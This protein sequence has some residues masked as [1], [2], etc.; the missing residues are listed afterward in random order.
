MGEILTLLNAQKVDVRHM[1][2]LEQND[3]QTEMMV[4][5]QVRDAK[6]LNTVCTLLKHQPKIISVE[7]ESGA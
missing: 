5:L 4:D 3:K 1:N 2:T 7:K 6:H